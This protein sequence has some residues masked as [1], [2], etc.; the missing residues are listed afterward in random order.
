MH[1]IFK[2]TALI[3]TIGSVAC[4]G[5]DFCPATESF[6]LQI[7]VVDSASGTFPAAGS[8]LSAINGEYSETQP[9]SGIAGTDHSFDVGAGRAGSYSLSIRTAGYRDWVRS[10][11]KVDADAC[12]QP[13]TVQLRALVQRATAP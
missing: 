6:A 7:T 12:G 10:G 11:L 1:R 4:G 9:P 13:K 3:A 5:P 8:V 2:H